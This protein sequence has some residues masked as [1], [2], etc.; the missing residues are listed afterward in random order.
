MP[1]TRCEVAAFS[2]TR[3]DRTK[4]VRPSVQ[5]GTQ[6]ACKPHKLFSTVALCVGLAPLALPSLSP[7]AVTRALE[8]GDG[9]SLVELGAPWLHR[10]AGAYRGERRPYNH[11]RDRK[12][13]RA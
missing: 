12:P 3:R 2:K 6:F 8:L 1:A 9:H 4:G 13:L 10:F 5:I 7:H 11:R